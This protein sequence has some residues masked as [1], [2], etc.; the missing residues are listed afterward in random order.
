[1]N[2]FGFDSELLGEKTK[3]LGSELNDVYAVFKQF[4]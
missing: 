2:D 3:L 1:M 4:L